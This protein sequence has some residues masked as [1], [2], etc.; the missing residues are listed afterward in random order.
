M[1][2][3]CTKSELLEAVSVCQK[4]VPVRTTIN[5]LEGI[6]IEAEEGLTLTA[7]DTNIGIEVK[8]F[9]DVRQ[10][11][12]LV[13]NAKILGDVIRKMPDEM[14]ELNQES[15]GIVTLSAGSSVFRL[16]VLEGE[17]YPKL[18]EVKES[19]QKLICQQEILKKMISKTISCISTDTSRPVLNGA[20][21]QKQSTTLEMVS[22]D[23]YRLALYRAELKEEEANWPD[24]KYIIPGKTLRELMSAL[25]E[26]EENLKIAANEQHIAFYFGQV[27]LISS[28]I[29]GEF[30]DYKKFLPDSKSTSLKVQ[31]RDLK[32]SFERALLMVSAEDARFPITVG[33]PEEGILSLNIETVRGAFNEQIEVIQE[34][35]LIEADYNPRFFM[36]A[37]KSIEDEQ[38]RID[39]TSK[40][41]PTMINPEEGNHFTYLLLPLR[42]R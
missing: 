5:I 17:S 7:F 3:L 39:F 1:R 2:F 35:D 19:E 12:K 23:G 8:C 26:G 36:D 34:G 37:L 18:P 29:K 27:K 31:T 10:T 15:E 16:K 40:V 42:G 13:L 32:Q 24:F 6:L 28:L 30:L 11:G 25:S 38:I 41:G 20:L 14:I 21:L 4:A 9:A 22:I 33:T